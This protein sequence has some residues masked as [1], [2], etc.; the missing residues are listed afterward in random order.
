MSVIIH[1]AVAPN[2]D[3]FYTFY[4][5]HA[6]DFL[7]MAGIHEDNFKFHLDE[8]VLNENEFLTGEKERLL[9]IKK[10]YQ[11]FQTVEIMK[12]LRI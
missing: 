8:I 10:L 7:K 9:E 6:L 2:K 1:K 4:K 5:N 12:F 11:P 3:D